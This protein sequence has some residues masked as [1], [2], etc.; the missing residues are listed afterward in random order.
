MKKS[1]LTLIVL[2]LS[3]L[4]CLAIDLKDSD[5]LV[6]EKVGTKSGSVYIGNNSGRLSKGGVFKASEKVF[7]GNGEYLK[8][9]NMRTKQQIIFSSSD[10]K[11]TN[12]SSASSFIRVKMLGNKGSNDFAE[13]V[14]CYPWCMVEDTVRIECDYKLNTSSCGFILK[15][16]PGD[17][18]LKPSV[19]FDTETNELVFYKQYFEDNGISCNQLESLLFHIEYWND[20]RVYPI[21]D[22]LK[23]IYIQ[24]YK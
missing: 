11:N 15:T 8:T 20:G 17:I 12:T 3:S 4:I 9:R 24:P 10:F 18:E 23:F 2:I 16:I 21:T 22:N 13:Y 6:I 7:L 14:S 19:P 1:F 5:M